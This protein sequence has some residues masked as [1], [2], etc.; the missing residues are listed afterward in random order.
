M[1]RAVNSRRRLGMQIEA[2]RDQN[3]SMDLRTKSGKRLNFSAF[4]RQNLSY[5]SDENGRSLSLRRQYG[6]SFSFEGSKLTKSELDE[7]EEAMKNV[8][9]LLQNFLQS[10]KVGELDPKGIIERAM[11][12]ADILP[13]P[14]SKNHQGAIMDSLVG[15]LDSMLR[16][17]PSMD[18]TSLLEDSKKLIDE[19]FQQIK[20]RLEGTRDAARAGLNL[21]A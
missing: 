11:G 4:E 20:K 10:S 6:F 21:Y 2:A 7:I 3:F 8:E 12:I 13:K 9:P 16:K 18:S 19:V 5:E 17:I 1:F 15:K 14:S